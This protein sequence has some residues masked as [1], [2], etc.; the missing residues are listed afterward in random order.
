MGL[1]CMYWDS[2]IGVLV[3]GVSF[4]IWGSGFRG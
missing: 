3:H 1:I 4:L 2:G